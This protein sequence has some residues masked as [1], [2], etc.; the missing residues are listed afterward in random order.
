M[1]LHI[2]VYMYYQETICLVYIW[3]LSNPPSTFE[4]VQTH[5]RDLNYHHHHGVS[6]G[7]KWYTGAKCPLIF[8][9]QCVDHSIIVICIL[10]HISC[11][12]Q[13]DFNIH[14]SWF[15]FSLNKEWKVSVIAT[16]MCS[17]YWL[18]L[19]LLSVA[20]SVN[21][22]LGITKQMLKTEFNHITNAPFRKIL[23][24]AQCGRFALILWRLV[25]G[26]FFCVF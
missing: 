17:S 24:S 13:C 19:G 16:N 6:L 21:G 3:H 8:K 22:R 25:K 23:N 26:S 4:Y 11:N 1:K 10:M 9:C 18:R 12:S 5:H 7:K 2:H 15:L 20:E 14:I